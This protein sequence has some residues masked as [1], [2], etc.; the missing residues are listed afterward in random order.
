MKAKKFKGEGSEGGE[1]PTKVLGT[2]MTAFVMGALL[3]IVFAFFV[4]TQINIIQVAE[5][6]AIVDIAHLLQN[7]LDTDGAINI[8]QLTNNGVNSCKAGQ[9]YAVFTDIATGKEW[10][11]G[12]ERGEHQHRLSISIRD[13][14]SVHPGVLYVRA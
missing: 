7:C 1:E 10:K 9:T 14:G 5:G 3:G 2:I 12:R 13:D 6:I 11:F 8:D 4:K